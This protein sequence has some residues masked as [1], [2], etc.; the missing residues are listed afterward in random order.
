MINYQDAVF[1]STYPQNEDTLYAT[2]HPEVVMNKDKYDTTGRYLIVLLSA[3]KGLQNFYLNYD[4]KSNKW[5]AN[6][7]TGEIIDDERVKWCGEQ[8][9]AHKK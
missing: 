9:D 8:I 5:S 6:E 1:T 7:N 2:F 3:D 4:N